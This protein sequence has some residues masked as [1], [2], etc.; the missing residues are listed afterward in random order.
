MTD[1][2]IAWLFLISFSLAI[3][4]ISENNYL[5]LFVLLIKNNNFK[6]QIFVITMR[7][8]KEVDK[9]QWLKPFRFLLLSRNLF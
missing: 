2:M 1:K 8:K 4:S 3:Q 6:D 7:K 5:F 9:D